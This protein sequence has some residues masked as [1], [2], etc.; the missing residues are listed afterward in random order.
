MNLEMW[1]YAGETREYV[2]ALVPPNEPL[3]S[4][5]VPEKKQMRRQISNGSL[6]SWASTTTVYSDQIGRSPH[7]TGMFGFYVSLK[8]FVTSNV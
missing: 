6:K 5:A 8:I 4:K 7:Q 3:R 1:Q 2:L